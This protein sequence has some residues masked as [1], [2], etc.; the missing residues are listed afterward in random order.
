M[1]LRRAASARTARA[2]SLSVLLTALAVARDQLLLRRR[3]PVPTL[4]P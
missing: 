2:V 3:A 4:A 1:T